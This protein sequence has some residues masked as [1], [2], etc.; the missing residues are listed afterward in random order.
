MPSLSVLYL[1]TERSL[2]YIII[3]IIIIIF[4]MMMMSIPCRLGQDVRP[5]L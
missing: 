5:G 1:K 2:L 4:I 3:I